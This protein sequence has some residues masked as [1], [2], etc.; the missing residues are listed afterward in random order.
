MRPTK[1]QIESGIRNT[2][3]Y[4]QED[5]Y[6]MTEHQAYTDGWYDA[7]EFSQQFKSREVTDEGLRDDNSFEKMLKDK[8]DELDNRDRSK[9]F[10]TAHEG[11]SFNHAKPDACKSNER[12]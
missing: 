9:D 11:E 3:K 5:G 10:R 12:R 7:I 1:L 8:K 2:G 4:R 6:S